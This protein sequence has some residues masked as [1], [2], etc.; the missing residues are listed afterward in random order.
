MVK[1]GVG[2]ELYKWAAKRG[3]EVPLSIL[4]LIVLIALIVIAI[5][6]NFEP[7]ITSLCCNCKYKKKSQGGCTYTCGLYK[8]KPLFMYKRRLQCPYEILFNKTRRA[9]HNSIKVHK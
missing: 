2:F 6:I 1:I 4:S 9:A 7:C 5:H 8:A 3:I